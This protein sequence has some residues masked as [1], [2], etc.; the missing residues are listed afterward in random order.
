MTIME[1]VKKIL[2]KKGETKEKFKQMQEDDRL[3]EILEERK[4]SANRRELERYY[5]EQEEEEIK[6]ALDKIRKQ[7]TR[8][9]WSGYSFLGHKSTILKDERP[10]L[11]ERN[12]F[13][14]NKN[15][16]TGGESMFK[17]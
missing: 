13:K 15:I 10:I 6:L 9:L 16:F 3:Q 5:K 17:W 1:S 11:K 4:K 2:G 14:G 12:I 7:K 8:E